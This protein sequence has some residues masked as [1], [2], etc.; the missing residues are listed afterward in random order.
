MPTEPMSFAEFKR[1][2]EAVG[3][4]DAQLAQMLGFE[5]PQHLRRLK[6]SPDKAHHK[7]VMPYTA[8]LMRA[9]VDGYRPSDWP[10]SESKDRRR[11]AANTVNVGVLARLDSLEAEIAALRKMVDPG[12][13]GDRSKG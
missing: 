13:A 3:L 7:R 11:G 2:Q 4:T 12:M 10:S 1:A 6:T 8:R 9:Y 5:D